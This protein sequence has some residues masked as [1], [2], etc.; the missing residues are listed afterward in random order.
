MKSKYI[1]L[2]A[3]TGLTFVSCDYF[4]T[5]DDQT[6]PNTT[7]NVKV[8]NESPIDLKYTFN[9]PVGKAVTGNVSATSATAYLEVPV[10]FK[11]IVI[12]N[13]ANDTLINVTPKIGINY[14]KKHTLIIT[15]YTASIGS[16]ARDTTYVQYGLLDN[17]PAYAAD[18][19]KVRS[20]NA[21]RA[22]GK[23]N[24][25]LSVAPVNTTTDSPLFSG[26]GFATF[27]ISYANKPAGIYNVSVLNAALNVVATSQF[28]LEA[29]NGY[30]IILKADNTLEL[31]KDN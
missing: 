29:K 6:Y 24:V 30:S 15:G 21:S 16:P 13:T 25:F 3:L 4:K 5:N 26:V 19:I 2:L 11:N 7:G 18:G 28:T 23:V 27:D 31:L 8:L 12:Q 20:L 1:I 17:S 10:G 22:A 9:N 14:D